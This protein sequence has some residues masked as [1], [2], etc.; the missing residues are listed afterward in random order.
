MKVINI[1]YLVIAVAFLF[2]CQTTESKKES[3]T[4]FDIPD[5][6]NSEIQRLKKLDP[7]VKKSVT[8][9]KST[10]THELKIVNWDN[11]FA[12]FLNYVIHKIG[13]SNFTK[14]VKGD[15]VIYISNNNKEK[16][17]IEFIF[18]NNK[19][20]EIDITKKSKNLLISN[21][22]HLHYIINKHYYI[23]KSQN[24]L[25]LGENNYTIKG[26]F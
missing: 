4:E 1:I 19:F 25:G 5:F 22:E 8:N 24:V 13:L 6:F 14:Q 21:Q 15:T 12:Q 2:S 20:S 3:K 18:K 7:I 16:I 17:I 9:N 11:E 26:V 10:E 23:N